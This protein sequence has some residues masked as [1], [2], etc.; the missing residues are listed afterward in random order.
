L[1]ILEDNWEIDNKKL[2]KEEGAD[3]IFSLLSTD[4]SIGPKEVLTSYKYQPQLEK[5]FKV[6]I[7]KITEDI[8]W[9]FEE[10]HLFLL[11]NADEVQLQ[12]RL[13]LQNLLPDPL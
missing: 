1:K 2:K 6:S 13:I 8:E 12:I 5:R 3:G 10:H 11:Q 9:D 4:K 7:I